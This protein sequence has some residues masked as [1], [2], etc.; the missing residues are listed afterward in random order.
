LNGNLLISE[1]ENL[2][3]NCQFLNGLIINT[4]NN[5]F[6]LDELFQILTKSSPSSLYKFKFD[7]K[8]FKLEDIKS[9]FNNWK[10]RKPML[11]KIYRSFMMEPD[12]QLV[13]LIEQYKTEGIIKKYS[14]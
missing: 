4:H 9:F 11:L 2:L 5:Q 12:Q 8:K 7:S 10:N 6:N 13:S 3:I 1:F 14:I